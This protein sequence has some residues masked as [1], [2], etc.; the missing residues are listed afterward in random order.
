MLAVTITIIVV[1]LLAA[2]PP[3]RIESRGRDNKSGCDG[4][5]DNS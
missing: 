1:V 2:L 3:A 4:K 5:R